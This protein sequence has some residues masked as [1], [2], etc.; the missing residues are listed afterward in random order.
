MKTLTIDLGMLTYAVEDHSGE[1][2]HYLDSQTGEIILV[3]DYMD[4][5][6]ELQEQI[7][8]DPDRYLWIEPLES[9]RSFEIMADFVE[10]LPEGAA[11]DILRRSLQRPKPFRNF[12]FDLEQ[13]PDLRQEWFRY[14]AQRL[15]EIAQEW[16]RGHAIVA[17]PLY[18]H[19]GT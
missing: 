1:H 19:G 2:R 7:D 16:L 14:H 13:Y 17:T 15:V 11:Q 9:H 10:S 3:S 5:R 4:E 8:S 18:P 6:E 12:K